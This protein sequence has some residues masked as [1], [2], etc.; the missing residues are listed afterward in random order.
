LNVP[1][2]GTETS[3]SYDLGMY[4]KFG[5]TFDAR[6]AGN[7]IKT[8]NYFVTNTASI[9]FNGSYA[10]QLDFMK[11]IGA[12]F[13]FNWKPLDKLVI[14]GNYSHLK[15]SYRGAIGR[16]P[17]VVLL[18][19]PPRDKSNMSLRYDFLFRTRFTADFKAIGRRGSEGGT[20]LGAFTTTDVGLEKSLADKMTLSFFVNNLFDKFY[21]QVYGYPAPGRT[22]GVR[23]RVNPPKPR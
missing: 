11:Y 22:F 18:D 3:L 1:P 12:E 20:Q 15:N 7:Y 2:L 21:Q 17:D 23:L 9:Y 6:L 5:K 19:I 14:F 16:L 8:N 10:Y 13:E 4:R